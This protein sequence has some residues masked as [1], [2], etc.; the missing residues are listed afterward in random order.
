MILALLVG[1]AGI[2]IVVFNL[3]NVCD[4]NFIIVKLCPLG[5]MKI[6]NIL[7]K[8]FPVALLGLSLGSEGA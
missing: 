5:V 3:L 1:L 8:T 4:K 2:H 7:L 6:M